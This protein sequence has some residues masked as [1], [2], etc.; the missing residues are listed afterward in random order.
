MSYLS[1]LGLLDRPFVSI[2]VTLG[3]SADKVRLR[4]RALSARDQDALEALQM[5]EYGR[6][7]TW[8]TEGTPDVEPEIERVAR[9]Y[10]TKSKQEIVGQILPTREADVTARALQQ[11]GINMIQEA[12]YM[13]TLPEEEQEAYAALQ[14]EK[15][16]NAKLE[17][18]EEVRAELMAQPVEQLARTMA[19][20]NVN[21]RAMTQSTRLY[22]NAFVFYSLY[23]PIKDERVF[24]SPEEV[25][26]ELTEGKVT[27]LVSI[28]KRALVTDLPFVSPVDGEPST[29]P[30][31]PST[32]AAATRRGGRRTPTTKESSK[33]STSPA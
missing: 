4:A 16:E 14:N 15:L 7:L 11:A 22:S 20:V 9:I 1:E 8:F 12:A 29:P 32:S 24:G 28:I 3:R 30:S 13:R 18:R 10:E 17:T 27:E 33:P 31:S 21:L 5:D 6:L 19:Q 25:G 2:D 23:Q 26:N